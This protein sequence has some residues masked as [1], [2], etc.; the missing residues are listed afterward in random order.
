MAKNRRNSGFTYVE[1][2][3]VL[4][5]I[6]ILAV[7]GLTSYSEFQARSRTESETHMIESYIE[8]AREKTSAGDRTGACGTYGGFYSVIG[9]S[10][11]VTLVPNGCPAAATYTLT[12]GFSLSEGD[13]QL[14]FQPQG[15]GMSGPTCIIVQH[16]TADLC[17]IIT[18]ESSGITSSTIQNDCSCS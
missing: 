13:F 11:V 14:D 3:I 17:G 5:I 10:S 18:I 1:M 8:L 9:A 16:P 7:T 15:G 4:L 2:M 12:D 6:G